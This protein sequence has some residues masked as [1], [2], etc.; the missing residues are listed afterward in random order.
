MKINKG[1]VILLCILFATLILFAANEF[2][3]IAGLSQFDT[4]AWT[5]F[6]VIFGGELLTFSLYQ[7]GKTKYEGQ[8]EVGLAKYMPSKNGEVVKKL[9]E[10]IE[11]A[12]EEEEAQKGKHGNAE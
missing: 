3:I 8:K 11:K 4:G 1:D 2:N 7:I 5:L 12:E 10:A 9:E 6:G